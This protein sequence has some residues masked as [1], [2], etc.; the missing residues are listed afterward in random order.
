MTSSVSIDREPSTNE[1]EVIK[2]RLYF[3]TLRTCPRSTLSVHY[4]NIDDEFHY[5]NFYADFGPLNLAM[6]YR[7]CWKLNETQGKYV[8]VRWTR[9]NGLCFFFQSSALTKK[10]IVHYTSYDN[11]RKRANAAYLVGA[12]A[13][14]YHRKSPEEVFASLTSGQPPYLPFRDASCGSYLSLRVRFACPIGY[15]RHAPDTCCDYFRRHNVTCVVRLN[16]KMYEAKRFREANF[17]HHDLYFVDGSTPDNTILKK[18]FSIAENSKGAIAVHCKAGLGRTGHVDCVVL[19]RFTAAEAI[20]WIRL[21]RPGSV[22]E[23]QQYYVAEK[24]A[25]L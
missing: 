24:Q 10:K 12:Y 9:S 6:L 21:C 15:P 8:F 25:W 20:A 13:I 22:I 19:Y 14:I 5:E 1:C 18:F 7:Y 4:F 3:A 11:N 16:R 2:D 17:D 23:P